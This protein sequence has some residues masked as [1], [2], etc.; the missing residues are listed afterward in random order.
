M[1]FATIGM[2]A[3]FW[4]L[5]GSGLAWLLGA[6]LGEVVG[7][8]PQRLHR[9]LVG[10]VVPHDPIAVGGGRK[11]RVQG[12]A[13]VRSTEILERDGGAKSDGFHVVAVSVADAFGLDD[14]V[15]GDAVLIIAT[16]GSVHDEA[17]HP[18][19]TEIECAGRRGEPDRTPPTRQ[20]LRCS[21]RRPHQLARRREDALGDERPLVR[22]Q[23]EFIFFAHSS[24]PWL[25]AHADMPRAGQDA[26]P[27][28]GGSARASRPPA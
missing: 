21:P 17:P 8:S 16:I 20:M 2:Q 4:F 24:F 25:G 28:V 22:L 10:A 23:L 27:T 14:L 1:L 19:G 5:L 15:K 3:P 26:P 12:E 13:R 11:Y 6:Q 9:A 18:T 7:Q